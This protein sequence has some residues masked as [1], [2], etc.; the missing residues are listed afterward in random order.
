MHKIQVQKS[1]HHASLR[2]HV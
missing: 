1:Y 2:P